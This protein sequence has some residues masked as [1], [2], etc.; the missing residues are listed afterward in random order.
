M[1]AQVT[2]PGGRGFAGG[3]GRSLCVCVRLGV[4]VDYE[5]V[6]LKT[7]VDEIVNSEIK[8]TILNRTPGYLHR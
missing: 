2:Q 3:L 4:C 8:G 7:T 1:S 5:S 6:S